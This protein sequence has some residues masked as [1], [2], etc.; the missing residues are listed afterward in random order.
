MYEIIT[1]GVF[2][3]KYLAVSDFLLNFAN[4]ILELWEE[5]VEETPGN[6]GSGVGKV[7]IRAFPDSLRRVH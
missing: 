1:T 7:V 3:K 5:T 6:T 2:C 4:K